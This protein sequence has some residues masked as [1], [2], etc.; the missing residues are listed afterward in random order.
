MKTAIVTDS[1]SGITPSEAKEL[2]LFLMPMPVFLDEQV[3]WEGLDITDE[4]FFGALTS[5]IDVRTSMPSPGDLLDQWDRIIEE[6]YDEI[7]YIPM[8]S[9]LSSSCATAAGLAE[10]YGHP[11]YVVD[12]HQISLTLRES[13]L[14]AREMAFAGYSGEKIRDTLLE[15]MHDSSIYITVDTLEFLK[16]G[17]RVTPAGAAIASVLNLKPVLTIQGE[18][19]DAFAKVRG[20]KR[21]RSKMLEAIQEDLATRF[22]AYDREELVIAVAGGG[23]SD[24]EADQW[25]AMLEK[26]LPGYHSYY[27]PLSFSIS[28][29]V[30]PGSYGVAICRH[31]HF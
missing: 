24:E 26:T 21:A 8:S 29:H 2:G 15:G 18:K 22:A 4:E 17:G 23:L 7:V 31:R 1:N 5:G 20:M 27:N 30:G 25:L 10:D 19:L 11:V 16:K 14:E 9:G 28:A 6:G 3:R 13:V 12:N